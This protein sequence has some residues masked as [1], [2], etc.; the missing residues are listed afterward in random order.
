MT[1]KTVTTPSIS[2]ETDAGAIAGAVREVATV[3]DDTIKA[4]NTPAETQG[5]L[6]VAEQKIKDQNASAVDRAI[7][8]SNNEDLDKALS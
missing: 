7:T 8:T 2:V 3:A 4:L 5:R 1:P 6:N